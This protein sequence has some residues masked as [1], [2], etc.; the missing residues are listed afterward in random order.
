MEGLG[1]VWRMRANLDEER[2]EMKAEVQDQHQRHTHPRHA[3][4]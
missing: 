4:A 2:T 3:D 1:E